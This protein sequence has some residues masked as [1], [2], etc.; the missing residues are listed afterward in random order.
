VKGLIH[1]GK[2][3]WLLLGCFGLLWVFF[4]LGVDPFVESWMLQWSSHGPGLLTPTLL[5]AQGLKAQTPLLNSPP[6]LAIAATTEV[7]NLPIEASPTIE[8]RTT[9][10]SSSGN[11]GSNTD[12]Y[13]STI[14]NNLLLPPKDLSRHWQQVSFDNGKILLQLTEDIRNPSEPAHRLGSKYFRYAGYLFHQLAGQI[15]E[16]QLTEQLTL[17]GNQAESLGFLVFQSGLRRFDGPPA[18][19]MT[20]LKIQNAILS[21]L[22]Q[23]NSQAIH[24]QDFNSAGVPFRSLQLKNSQTKDQETAQAGDA[25]KAF[26]ATAKAIENNPAFYSLPESKKLVASQVNLL[27]QL[28]LH[29]ELR[30]ES[31]F[32][33]QTREINACQGVVKNMKIYAVQTLPMQTIDDVERFAS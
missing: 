22:S 9:P 32:D 6:L 11:T 2:R 27:K 15:H 10:S 13:D 25:L 29:L 30:W 1:L 31:T 33:C 16:Q 20:H 5:N 28:A 12:I 14:G 4:V 7:N 18:E 26:L 19:D 23:L 8:R 17:L 21:H 24:V 3:Y